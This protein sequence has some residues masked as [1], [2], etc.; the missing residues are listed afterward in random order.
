[1][2]YRNIRSSSWGD[3][4]FARSLS[5]SLL[6]KVIK[7]LENN[8]PPLLAQLSQLAA[9]VENGAENLPP[10][11]MQ[12]MEQYAA[13][14]KE[15]LSED[16]PKYVTS[17]QGELTKLAEEERRLN[18]NDFAIAEL[19]KR[20]PQFL[21]FTDEHRVLA[22]EYNLTDVISTPPMPLKN[23][24]TLAKLD[25]KKLLDAAKKGDKAEKN[26]LLTP[27]NKQLFE[28]FRETWTQS[29]IHV[30]FDLEGTS[31]SIQIVDE[32]ESFS[33][34]G[35]RSDGL[36]Q[37]VA[38]QTF[39]TVE[40]ANKPILLIDEAELHLH[41]DG[42]A[43]LVQMLTKQS[44]APKVIYSTHSAGCLPED[45]GVGVRLLVPNADTRTSKVQN[46]F[47]QSKD[48][49]FSPLLFGMGATTLAFFPIRFA[50]VT[51]GPTE[52]LLLP[53]ILRQVTNQE[54]LGFQVVPGLSE[55]SLATLPAMET[56]GTRVAYFIDADEGGN[57]LRLA[58]IK[59][60]VEKS[61]ILR[62]NRPSGTSYTTEDFIDTQ[63]FVKAVNRVLDEFY[64]KVPKIKQRD[65]SSPRRIKNLDAYCAAHGIKPLAKTEIAYQ[66]LDFI[67]HDP[68]VSIID[69]NFKSELKLIYEKI[70]E[71]L[72]IKI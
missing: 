38:L 5:N 1:M 63:C 69:P 39:T 67:A 52:M 27:A 47:W 2:G 13:L 72:G 37:F 6:E 15:H 31:L 33:S 61:H 7:E 43:D 64:P 4:A 32:N 28:S 40:R 50:L 20:I 58:L 35:E 30:H 23:L 21:E 45:L 8:H 65:V 41:Y 53:T 29:G 17:L 66:L 19:K 71:E 51:E 46:K 24:A 56:S 44:V 48:Q 36:R 18:P 26:N 57:K 49:G 9:N 14:L 42:Q 62:V 54:Y 70:V 11:L 12:L 10:K 55:T 22:A 59:L 25:L 3:G 16:L 60:G 68:N 34:L